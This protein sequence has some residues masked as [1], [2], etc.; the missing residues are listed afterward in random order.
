METC[1]GPVRNEDGLT[2]PEVIVTVAIMGIAFVSILGGMWTAIFTSDVHRKQALGT[3]YLINAAEHLKSEVT[4]PYV[5]CGTYSLAGL[6]TSSVPADWQA[7][8]TVSVEYFTVDVSDPDDPQE[9]FSAS[10]SDCLASTT[11]YDL[12][13]VTI[14]ANS[15]VDSRATETLTFVKRPE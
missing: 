7:E 12:Q 1:R 6:S 11:Y 4:T 15:P 8:M 2:L 9:Q 13:Q 14:T 5:P 10:V 3:T